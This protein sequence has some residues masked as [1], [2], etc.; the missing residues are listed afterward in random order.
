MNTKTSDYTKASGQLRFQVSQEAP[1]Y[2]KWRPH[3][4]KMRPRCPKWNPNS[5]ADPNL[6]TKMTNKYENVSC[7]KL[8]RRV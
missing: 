2:S 4:T 8:E 6:E 1:K 5:S 7:G 3:V